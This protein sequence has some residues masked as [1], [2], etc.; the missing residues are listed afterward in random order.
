MGGE[1][2]DLTIRLLRSSHSIKHV[3]NARESSLLRIECSCF[4]KVLHPRLNGQLSFHPSQMNRDE[5]TKTHMPQREMF[6]VSAEQRGG[7]VGLDN[8]AHASEKIGAQPAP[9]LQPVKRPRHQ[10]LTSDAPRRPLTAYNLFFQLERENIINGQEDLNY[11]YENVARIAF[12]HYEQSKTEAPK[13]K[14]RKSHGKISFAELART[15]ANKWRALDRDIKSLFEERAAM[16]KARHQR[17]IQE[18]ACRK[19]RPK[20]LG[21]GPPS[22]GELETNDRPSDIPDGSAFST[23]AELEDSA[24]VV[25]PLRMFP[26]L[27]GSR[28][29]TFTESSDTIGIEPLSR[30]NTVDMSRRGSRPFFQHGPYYG[31]APEQ[32]LTGMAIYP[33]H[34]TAMATIQLYQGTPLT[35]Y[36]KMEGATVQSNSTEIQP[37][38]AQYA[39]QQS[40][41]EAQAFHPYQLQ[42]SILPSMEPIGIGAQ[43]QNQ[44]FWPINYEASDRAFL[45]SSHSFF[46]EDPDEAADFEINELLDSLDGP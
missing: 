41:L 3:V 35:T 28:Y 32:N 12:V 21:I 7:I 4:T 45:P 26:P 6:T 14:H 24:Q 33:G 46:P 13:R 8:I 37:P 27:P 43:Q 11:N 44:A 39:Q 23:A 10:K 2:A 1:G 19:L 25:L 20:P 15:I 18:W 9:K 30:M 42:R 5:E 31:Y 40:M 36:Q 38:Y 16:E 17:E 29:A 22:E 34:A